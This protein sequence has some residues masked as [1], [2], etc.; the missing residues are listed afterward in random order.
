MSKRNREIAFIQDQVKKRNAKCKRSK[1]L[2]TKAYE[3]SI[4]CNLK[5]NL[6]IFDPTMNRVVEFASDPKLKMA[7]LTS[8]IKRDGDLQKKQTSIKKSKYKLVT[9]DD[10]YDCLVDFKD[11]SLDNHNDSDVFEDEDLNH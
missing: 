10:L 9:P 4:L 6:S 7:D 8:L 1:N 3:L 11:S 2:M 5:V